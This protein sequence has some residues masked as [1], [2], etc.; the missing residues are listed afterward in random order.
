MNIWLLGGLGKGGEGVAMTG[1]VCAL[2]LNGTNG[3]E[4]KGR[5]GW[6]RRREGK[7][8][9]KRRPLCWPHSY[10]KTQ[11]LLHH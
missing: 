1:L 3:G 9:H 11:T 2:K 8:R 7:G 4:R 6:K 10:L 5:E